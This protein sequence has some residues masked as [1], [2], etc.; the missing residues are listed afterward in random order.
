MSS[1]EGGRRF[2]ARRIESLG[3]GGSGVVAS[4]G[5]AGSTGKGSNGDGVVKS[6]DDSS[7]GSCG[8]DDDGKGIA[9]S[10]GEDGETDL[11]SACASSGSYVP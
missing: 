6:C 8:G 7:G 4:G 1:R 11:L 5:S 3:G 2:G 10:K 9:F